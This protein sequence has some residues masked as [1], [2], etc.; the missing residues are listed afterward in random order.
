[1]L[2]EKAVPASKICFEITETAAIGNMDAAI[3]FMQRLRSRGCKIALD[4][5]GSG[6][7]SFH[8][9]RNLPCDFLKIDGSYIRDIVVNESDH[10]LVSA[11]H[12]VAKLL[13]VVTIAE[14][15]ES[16][17]ID[18]RVRKIGVDYRQGRHFHLSPE[19]IAA[20]AEHNGT[21]PTEE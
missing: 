8:Y 1:M 14:F 5:F 18:S 7:S 15:V 10:T 20:L 21:S 2:S 19:W 9:L 16:A 4:D 17:A 12:G 13:G 3:A 11:I 6:L